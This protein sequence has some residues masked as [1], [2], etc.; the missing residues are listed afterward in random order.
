[1]DI[2]KEYINKLQQL[3]SITNG[4]SLITI[5]QKGNINKSL[6]SNMIRKEKSLSQN[7]K[8][9]NVKKEVINS[10]KYCEQELKNIPH[11]I[12]NNGLVLIAGNVCEYI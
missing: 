11:T 8:D 6:L 10:L 3:K 9:K 4:T 5:Y 12:S 1:M 7:I 2:N